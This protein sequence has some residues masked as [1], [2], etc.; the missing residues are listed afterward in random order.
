MERVGPACPLWQC[1]GTADSAHQVVDQWGTQH[2]C[3]VACSGKRAWIV[4]GCLG[5]DMLNTDGPYIADR[6]DAWRVRSYFSGR[7]KAEYEWTAALCD[8]H[9]NLRARVTALEAENARL[10][11]PECVMAAAESLFREAGVTTGMNGGFALRRESDGER[12]E[13]AT[14]AEAFGKVRDGK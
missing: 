11:T 7:P 12:C 9:E 4:A 13:G 2:A 8:S 5:R 1:R 6:S 14:L 3:C 10:K